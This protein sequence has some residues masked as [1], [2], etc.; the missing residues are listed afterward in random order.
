MSR[1][2]EF[3]IQQALERLMAGRT[4]IVIAHRL[5]TIRNADLFVVLE[6]SRIVDLGTHQELMGAG[7]L[8]WRLNEVQIGGEPKWRAISESLPHKLASAKGRA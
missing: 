1:E 5:S 7:G 6:D 3:L 2:T 4:A 8:Y